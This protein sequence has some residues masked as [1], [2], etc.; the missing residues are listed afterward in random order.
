MPYQLTMS[1]D[2]M[3]DIGFIL[4]SINIEYNVIMSVQFFIFLHEILDSE[5]LVNGSLKLLLEV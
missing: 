3:F 5:N 1:K 4:V 2:T